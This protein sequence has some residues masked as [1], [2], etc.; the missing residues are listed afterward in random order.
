MKYNFWIACISFKMYRLFCH[1]MQLLF[2]SSP[3]YFSSNISYFYNN[4]KNIW[5]ITITSP[6]LCSELGDAGWVCYTSSFSSLEKVV[7]AWF[8]NSQS[9]CANI[10]RY[11]NCNAVD[12]ISK[13]TFGRI[14]W[15]FEVRLNWPITSIFFFSRHFFRT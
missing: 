3:L 4:L 7:F 8:Y 14:L 5:V 12:C 15:L 2:N 11:R 10:T 1:M 9:V 13:F 6:T